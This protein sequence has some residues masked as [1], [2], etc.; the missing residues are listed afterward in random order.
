[1][2]LHDLLK[3]RDSIKM[4]DKEV[5]G[6]LFQEMD[7]G[8]DF[9]ES[10]N[11]YIWFYTIG[12][13]FRP[14]VI[15]E[16]GTRFGYSLKAFV[17]GTGRPAS[18]LSL[19]AYDSECDGLKTL[20]ICENYFKE[21]GVAININRSDTRLL[22]ALEANNADLVMVDAYHTEDGAF[23]ECELAWNALKNGGIIVFDDA[24]EEATPNGIAKK[25]ALNFCSKYNLMPYYLPSFRG[26]FLIEK[27]I[28]RAA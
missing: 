4:T 3:L 8:M 16:M 26:I 20:H 10:D 13:Y 28:H 1:M 5:I 23:H 12:K 14:Q 25:G 27:S 6:E 9:V 2:N 17:D 19:W 18:D 24:S 22:T 11:N 21:R 15:V 7:S